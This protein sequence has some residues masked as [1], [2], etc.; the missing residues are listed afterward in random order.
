M[1]LGEFIKVYRLENEMTQKA[2][3]KE[4]CI[5]GSDAD[6]C[7]IEKG[8]DRTLNA[9]RARFLLYICLEKDKEERRK[10]AKSAMRADDLNE[11]EK[12]FLLSVIML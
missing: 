11:S 6:V 5:P 9:L 8:T 12:K 10:N 1:R 4:L 2:L 3:A 7:R